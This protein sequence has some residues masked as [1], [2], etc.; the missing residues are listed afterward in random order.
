MTKGTV[1]ESGRTYHQLSE[2]QK[3]IWYLEKAYP[4]T[5]LNIVAGTLR[6]KGAVNY[7]ALEKAVNVFV[8]K[9]DSMRLRVFESNGMAYQYI[10][11]HADFK[12][13]YFDFSA[14]EGLKDLFA[15]D[16]ATTRTPFDIIENPL[17][18]CAMFKV[19]EDEGG[20]YMKMHHLISDAWTMGIATRQIIDLY[21]KIKK[22]LE[23]D[24]TPNPSYIEHLTA[25]AAYEQS[26]RFERDRDYWDKKF[27]KPPEMTSLKPQKSGAATTK[28]RRK[29]LITP[30]KLSNKIREFC[31]TERLSVFTLFMSA[32]SIYINRVTGIEDIVLGTTILNRTNAREK[33]TTGMFVSVAAPIRITVDDRLD[34][35]TFSGM[36]LRENTEVLRHQK[37]PY[38]YI[39][40]DLKKKHK[41]A[42]RLFDI[43]LNYQNL[44][45]RKNESDEDYVAKWIFSGHQVESLVISIN[46]REDGGN[47][48]IDYDFLTDVF[49]IR[50][51]EFIHQHIISL[52]WH[53]LDNPTKS[54][55]RLDMISEKEKR[56]ILYEFNDTRVDYPADKTLH[57]IFEEQAEKTPERTALI[58]NDRRM[59][60]AQLNER[61][62][63]LA[64]RLQEM[65]VGPDKIVGIMANRSF[66][67]MAGILAIL[68]AGGAYMPVDPAYPAERKNYMLQNSRAVLLLAQQDLKN[69]VDF[70]GPVLDLDDDGSYS[71]RTDNPANTSGPGNL[72]YV[73]YTSGSTGKPKGVMIEH[74]SAVNRINWMQKNYP[75]GEES[76]IIQKTTYSFDVS[77]WELFW[78]FFAGS[79][80]CLIRSGEEKDPEAM[81]RTI[82]EHRVTTMHFVPSM[83]AVFLDYVEKTGAAPRLKSLVNVFASG[84]AL[85]IGQVR[86]FNS[87]LYETN[88]TRLT[89][90]YGPTEATVDVSYF[91]CSP[92]PPL[93]TVPIG[94]PIDN[95]SLYIMDK[96]L[97]LLPVGIPG[98]LY[99]GGVGVARGYLNNPELTA[100]RFIKN[101]YKPDEILYKTGDRARWYPKGDIEFLGRMDFQVKVR[102]FRIELGEIEERLMSHGAVLEAAVKAFHDENGMAFLAAYIV[103][104]GAVDADEL[105]RYLAEQLPD[106]MV[107]ASFVFLDK[108]PLN[109]SGK[110]D[111][112]ALEKPSFVVPGGAYEP[113]ADALEEALAEIWQRALGLGRVGVLDEYTALGGDSLNAIRIIT[114]I[115]KAFGAELSP[116]AI[117]ELKTVRG[118]A[119]H[120][121]AAGVAPT[122]APLN[123]THI[124]PAP[125]Q[126][127]YALSSAQKRQF[128]LHQMGGGTSYNMPGGLLI[129]GPLDSKRLEDAIRAIIRRHEPLRTT[130]ET[131]DGEPVQIIHEDVGFDLEYMEAESV[132]QAQRMLTDGFIRPF[133]LGTA[134]LLR[135]RLVSCGENRHVLL[136]DMHHIISD[137]ASINIL[138]EE[139]SRLYA[140]IPLPELPVS[141][142]DYA[143]WHNALL[144]SDRMKKQEAYW[145]GKFS[146]EIPVLNM[147]ADY[148]RPAVRS[149]RGDTLHYQLDGALVGAVRKLATE[150]GTT[151]F[152]LLLAAYSVLLSRYTGQED[153]V[154][155][156]PVEGRRHAELRGLLGMFVNTLAIRSTPSGDKTFLEFLS[157]IRGDLLE[158]YDNQDYPFEELVEKAGVKRDVS[159][160]PLFDTMFILQNMDLAELSAGDITARMFKHDGKTAK[161]DLAFEAA[162]K[163]GGINVSVEYCTDLFRRETIGRLVA[164]YECLLRDIAA[165]PSKKLMD[166]EIMP[167]AER[168]RLLVDFNDTQAEYPRDKTIHRLFEEQAGKTP[169]SVAL[170]LGGRSMTYGEL[171]SKANKLARRLRACG[172]GPDA[173]VGLVAD[174]SFDMIVSILGI[175][176]AGGAYMPIDPEYPA[177]RKAYMLSDSGAALLLLKRGQEIPFDGTVLYLD[178][179][180]SYDGDGANPGYAV[181]PG[182]LAYIIYTSGSTGKPKGVMIEHRNVVRLL[183]NDKFQ[184]DF[185]DRDTWTLFHSCCFDFSV[186]EMYG[187]LLY[188]GRLIIIPREDAIDTRRFLNILKSEK[189]TVL[190]QTPSAFYNLAA[191]D[192]ASPAAI[193]A[194]RYVVFGGEA[195]KPPMLKG[196]KTKYP[197]TKLINMYGITETT[198]HVTFKEITLEDTERHVSNVGRP[199]PTLSVYILDR[200][201]KLQPIGV[202]GEICVGGDGVARGYLNNEAL[203]SQRFIEIRSLGPGRIYRSGDL[204]RILPDGDIEYLGRIDNQVKIRGYRIELGEIESALEQHPGIEKTVVTVHTTSGG[205]KKLCAYYTSMADLSA[206]EL[207]AY[208]SGR[209]PEYMLPAYFIRVDAFALNRNGKID[210]GALPQPGEA[211]GAGAG[212]VMPRNATEEAI[213]AAWRKVLDVPSVGIDDNFFEL[214]GDSLSVIRI[215]SM[216]KMELNVIDFFTHPTIR[217][218]SEK[219]AGGRRTSALLTNLTPGNSAAGT[220]IICFPYGGGNALA[221]KNMADALCARRTDISLY[222]VNL[223]GHEYGTQE[224]LESFEETADK[225]ADI[226]RE[227]VTGELVLYG[228]C[229]GSAMMLAAA[230]RLEKAGARIKSVFIGGIM[231]P[232]F[233][234]ILGAFY[235]PW[236]LFSDKS[237]AR[238]LEKIGMPGQLLSDT[239]YICHILRVFRHDTKCFYRYLYRQIKE[240][241]KLSCPVHVLVGDGDGTTRGYARRYRGWK[242]F[243]AGADLT[244]LKGANHYFINSHADEVIDHLLRNEGEA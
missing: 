160:N 142:K 241:R 239:D 86:Q 216:L 146:D 36:M 27:E 147:P 32:L 50:E 144:K 103:L 51:I 100:E 96:N 2:S 145:L 210:R 33:E 207:A 166:L 194:L 203:T 64:H 236:S 185:D 208:L 220:S 195:L 37:Y 138:A 25:N 83:L 124:P 52:L 101:P 112:N 3:S 154:I 82:E 134:P 110:T 8:R 184:F 9:S 77:V 151:L 45:L 106:Y 48:I 76:R 190:N 72:A 7:Q 63:R 91:E 242:R 54:I 127:A 20:F 189:V 223:P 17:F 12:I 119:A 90:L 89:N 62:N 75:Q 56:T 31:S 39:I 38:N 167:E 28:A 29:T 130:F 188:G 192:A 122:D 116:K 213:A 118:L 176:K 13:D 156:T 70:D 181:N 244:V 105:R 209:L 68:K 115:H 227:C 198:V 228:H 120:L 159:R 108:M 155:G 193:P 58:F 104:S 230:S 97:N 165:S 214:G 197:H 143:A 111:R 123:M 164:H 11:D 238:F 229:V 135:V 79:S 168:R 235:T 114:E 43:V 14:G 23:I 42:G 205:D 171:N 126:E 69:T 18:Y 217:Q 113:P 1:A 162:E 6:F 161:F 128:I 131:R 35:K 24:E 71:G 26:A 240:R 22:G 87:L 117:F 84:E 99:I 163:D 67:M 231:A 10:A 73:I 61:A 40:R 224:Q 98:E 34:F 215:I 55:S 102:G 57:Q 196:F 93:N 149:N 16:E 95:I 88:G 80:L 109:N 201:L 187:A 182:D 169:D 66:E 150:T 92:T 158:A 121:T 140:G 15:W 183:F 46:D 170:V 186:W 81:I 59:T 237:V 132:E 137:G 180:G 107:P 225:L 133:D 175:L 141:Y 174:R 136:F 153:I 47:L 60:Y 152:M 200:H 157:E 19:S 204:G 139:L 234:G 53:A 129:T 212:A 30:L 173:V 177:E 233:V 44:K 232:R 211:L 243:F 65:G 125:K 78:W 74:T 219:L 94:K 5:S 21:S 4:G 41:L 199:I 172:V 178:D 179:D 222:A 202:P 218:L 148:P 49:D 226:I 221:Y 85:A 191:E 206:R